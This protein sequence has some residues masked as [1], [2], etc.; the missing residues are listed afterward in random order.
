MMAD[1]GVG[2]NQVNCPQAGGKSRTS[3]GRARINESE[4]IR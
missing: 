4:T 2:D 3:K 1:D